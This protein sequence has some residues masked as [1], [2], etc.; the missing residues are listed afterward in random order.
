VVELNKK[1]FDSSSSCI[2]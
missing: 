2:A 1:Q